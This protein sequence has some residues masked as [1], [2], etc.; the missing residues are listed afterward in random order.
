[1]NKSKLYLVC[2][3]LVL[4]AYPLYH[5]N[6][7]SLEEKRIAY[8]TA[9]EKAAMD[10][11]EALKA[12]DDVVPTIAQAIEIAEPLLKDKY[13]SEVIEKAKPFVVNLS[14]DVWFVEGSVQQGEKEETYFVSLDKKTGEILNVSLR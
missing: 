12:K 13:G 7:K 8:K 1:M 10:Q 2:F 11:A 3:A 6:N 5:F 14:N 4:V 9:K